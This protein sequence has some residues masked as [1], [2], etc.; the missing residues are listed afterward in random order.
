[1]S[2]RATLES[3]RAS[4]A[5]QAEHGLQRDEERGHVEGLEEGL[6]ALL[7]VAPRIQGRLSQQNR[8]LQVS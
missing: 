3:A 8:M 7:T 4:E 1:M 2:E 6:G 5:S